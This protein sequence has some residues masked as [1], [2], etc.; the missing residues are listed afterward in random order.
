MDKS[1]DDYIARQR[2]RLGTGQ[3]S[4]RGFVMSALAAGIA[5]PTAIG[6]A[7][8]ARAQAPSKGG[9]LRLG[10][11]S[12]STTDTL[13]P[14]TYEGPVNTVLAYLYGNNLV[15]VDSSG[16][17]VPEL[18]SEWASDDAATWVFKLREGVEFHNGKSLA[19]EDVIASINHHRGEDSK[20][21]VGGLVSQIK[22]IRADGTNVVFELSAPNA[23]FPYV[24][25][26]YHL[27]ILPA[28]DGA[29]DA[30]G[31][32]G[33][34]GY[35]LET[36]EP[37]VRIH[38]TRF[39]NYFKAD[40]AHFDAV[41]LIS[42]IDP[43]ARQNA[44]MNGD[45]D[46]IDR[47]DPKTVSLLAR[48]PTLDILERPSTLHYTFPM[49]VDAA[50]FDNYD[51]RMALKLA[52]KRQ[53]LV[54]KILL[55]HGVVGNDH[56]ISTANRYHAELPQREFD[57]EQAAFHYKK[58]GHSGA[59]QLS[60]SDAAFSGAVDAAQLIAASASEAGIEIEVVREPND[61]YWSDVWNKKPWCVSYWSG[62]PTEDWMFS[63]GYTNDT[64]WNETAWRTGEAADRFNA[65]VV[66]A[67][68]ELDDAKRREL[69]A[70]AQRLL[71]DDGGALTP[72]FA[73]HISAVSK[74]I[75]HGD[76]IASNWEL[77]G[78]KAP[79]RWWT[80]S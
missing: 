33:S 53:E 26:D 19:P 38:A 13:D 76:D 30:T 35:V 5:L 60:A 22:D 12:G 8:A 43:T 56:P 32:V 77:D 11:G 46:A 9:L 37:G 17:L 27:I 31:G 28:S 54:D 58:S 74:G 73:N 21:A 70:E 80:A 50:P 18:A 72:M 14:A 51:L 40:R 2:L 20:S 64:E 10:L 4:R 68:A 67:R 1:R 36:Y 49:R 79:E 34:G 52:V 41:E 62:R 69:Y 75:G 55:G 66:E 61:G 63:S 39:A 59:L 57:P 7:D 71:A 42:I 3:V 65:I 44:I 15:E 25:S 45:V 29:I 6:W 16:K 78:A 48:V 23:D 24:L 47:V